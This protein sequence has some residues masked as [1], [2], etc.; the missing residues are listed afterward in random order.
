MGV[1]AGGGAVAVAAGRNVHHFST[2]GILHGVSSVIQQQHLLLY[3]KFEHCR[4][5][6]HMLS[7]FS[8]GIIAHN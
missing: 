4:Q 1:A 2:T 5:H 8:S 3:S 7:Y 6:H